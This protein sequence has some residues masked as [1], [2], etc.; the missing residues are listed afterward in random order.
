MRLEQDA[1]LAEAGKEDEF[2]MCCGDIT[3]KEL[4][5][6]VVKHARE[7]ELEYLRELGVCEKVDEARSCC[8]EQCHAC[9][10][11][12]GRHDKAFEE[13]PLQIRSRIVA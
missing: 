3:G 9:R 2:I 13:E 5:W 8:K 7:K 6:Q 4:P 10:H 11:K 12:V 1:M